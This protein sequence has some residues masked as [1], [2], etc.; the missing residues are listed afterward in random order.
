[1]RRAF[2]FKWSVYVRS[3][4][5]EDIS[6]MTL[7]ILQTGRTGKERILSTRFDPKARPTTH[8]GLGAVCR[9]KISNTARF[10]SPGY[11]RLTNPPARSSSSYRP[12]KL[13]TLL[14]LEPVT[15]INGAPDLFVNKGSTINL[16]CVVKYAPEPPPTMTWSHNTNVS[17]ALA[18][19][20]LENDRFFHRSGKPLN[21]NDSEF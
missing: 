8:D 2:I 20:P 11:S 14:V 5:L 15:I 17:V 18:N 12:L 13:T 1:M 21:F 19:K 3:Y 6:L 16:T 4:I 7:V 10:I 9:I